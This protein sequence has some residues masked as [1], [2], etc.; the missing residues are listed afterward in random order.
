MKNRNDNINVS[1]FEFKSIKNQGKLCQNKEFCSSLVMEVFLRKK[2][3]NTVS[4]LYVK[5]K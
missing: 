2:K 5:N 1:S 3:Q 4:F